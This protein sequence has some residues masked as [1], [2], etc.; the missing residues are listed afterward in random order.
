MHINIP[1]FG[2]TDLQFEQVGHDVSLGLEETDLGGS[3]SHFQDPVR[4][5][6][7]PHRTRALTVFDKRPLYKVYSRPTVNGLLLSTDHS[8]VPERVK[9]W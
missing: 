6:G 1:V 9:G 4:Q 2:S 5:V 3:S 7:A 8:S